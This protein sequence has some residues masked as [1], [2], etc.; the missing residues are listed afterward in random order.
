M[1]IILHLKVYI[2]SNQQSNIKNDF[3]APKYPTQHKSH[4]T[5]DQ[6]IENAIFKMAAGCHIGFEGQDKIK[7][8][9]WHH[10]SIFWP[11][12]PYKS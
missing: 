4:G 12:I 3:L 6:I 5:G 7:W 8:W 9:N 11:K 10:K 2:E 1:M